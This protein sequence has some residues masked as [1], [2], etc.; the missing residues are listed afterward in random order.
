LGTK[1]E[2]RR[3]KKGKNHTAKSKG[4]TGVG[5]KL[6]MRSKGARVTEAGDLKGGRALRPKT[7]QETRER[8]SGKQKAAKTRKRWSSRIK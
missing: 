1:P 5:C 3:G 4:S 7:Q 2:T 8:D 6:E